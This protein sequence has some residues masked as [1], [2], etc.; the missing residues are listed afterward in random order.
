MR[1]NPRSANRTFR[2]K[3]R[4]R[5]AAQAAPCHIC[6]G[7]ID[8]TA[9]SD[10]AHPLSLVI[11]EIKPVSRWREFGYDSPE[12][13]ALDPENLAPAHRICNAAKGARTLR[14]FQVQAGNKGAP[15]SPLKRVVTRDGE[16]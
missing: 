9:P 14:E 11:D 13:A 2:K 3:I 15:P 16:W 7:A 5:F 10:W 4:A 8:Y 1:N 12:A 6:R